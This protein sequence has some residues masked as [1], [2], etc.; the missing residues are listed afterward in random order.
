MVNITIKCNDCEFEEAPKNFHVAQS[1]VKNGDGLQRQIYIICPI[2]EKLIF[3]QHF[4]YNAEYEKS[5]RDNVGTYQICCSRLIAATL[6]EAKTA[7]EAREVSIRKLKELK[8]KY[9][10][11]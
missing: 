5:L 10:K 8:E 1:F 6:E 3:F 11:E 2:C 4:D 9:R 7:E